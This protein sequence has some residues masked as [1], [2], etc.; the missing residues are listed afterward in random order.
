MKRGFSPAGKRLAAPAEKS[1]LRDGGHLTSV[2]AMMTA[3][4]HPEGK[5]LRRPVQRKWIP[6]ASGRL[7]SRRRQLGREVPD[8]LPD[9]LEHREIDAA[10]RHE[11]AELAIGASTT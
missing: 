5:R 8:R 1:G 9:A 6:S 3:H 4:L 2:S 10:G 7:G 11:D